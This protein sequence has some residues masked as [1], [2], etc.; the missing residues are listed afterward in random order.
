MS[1]RADDSAGRLRH[2]IES[3]EGAAVDSLVGDQRRRRLLQMG[4]ITALMLLVSPVAQAARRIRQPSVV[5]VRIWPADEYTRVTL[6]HDA[7]IRFSQFTVR[8]PDRLVVDLEGVQLNKV[9]RDIAGGVS[10]SDPYISTL[11]VGEPRPGVVR[12]VMELKAE[13]APQV[14]TLPPFGSYRHRLVL[15]VY[16]AE[17]RDALLGLLEDIEK[18]A[19]G[20]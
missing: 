1:F 19:P 8:N 9:L 15:D 17:P 14:F 6:E 10:D 11:R 20:E 12:L 2:G 7:P 18:R 16:P 5:A 3:P 13:V 4:G